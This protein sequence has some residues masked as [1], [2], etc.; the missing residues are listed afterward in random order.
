MVV[1]RVC[2]S[3]CLSAAVRPHY[4]TDQ[5]VTWG[6][7]R[8]CH[9]VVHYWAICNGAQVALLWQHNAN[10]QCRRVHALYSLYD[11]F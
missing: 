11:W 7:G 1:T 8:G 3:V 6:S 5:D 10:A 4:C 2:V 9:L